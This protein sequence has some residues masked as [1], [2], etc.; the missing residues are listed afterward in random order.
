[1][2]FPSVIQLKMK[3]S[4][5]SITWNGSECQKSLEK[6]CMKN[7]S[8]LI[9]LCCCMYLC[10]FYSFGDGPLISKQMGGLH[11]AIWES[12]AMHLQYRLCDECLVRVCFIAGIN[13][14]VTPEGRTERM[15][16]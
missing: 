12:L 9:R 1:M 11:L 10:S 3:L 16:V 15:D 2:A 5:R 7:D 13:L 14:G 4:M 6:N 8:S